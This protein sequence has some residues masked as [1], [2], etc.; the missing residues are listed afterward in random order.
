MGVQDSLSILVTDTDW[1]IAPLKTRI[2]LSTRTQYVKLSTTLAALLEEAPN[3][4]EEGEAAAFVNYAEALD[5][6]GV[7][8]AVGEAVMEYISMQLPVVALLLQDE[9]AQV[10]QDVV[11]QGDFRYASSTQI[12]LRLLCINTGT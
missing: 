9:I 10:D 8:D 7:K 4:F 5:L 3:K 2:H 6:V 1:A 12:P 11:V